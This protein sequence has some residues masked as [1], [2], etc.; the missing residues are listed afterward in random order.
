MD[1]NQPFI[2]LFVVLFFSTAFIFSFSH[3]GAQAVEKITNASGKFSD[4]TQIGFLDVSGKTESEAI[5]LME[6]TYV[7]WL[8]NTS[9]E[10]QCEEIT[11]PFDV[12]QFKLNSKQT[13]DSIKDGQKNLAFITINKSQVEEQVQ[14]LFPQL[15]SSNFD[16]DKLT[17]SL[18][19][20]ASLYEKG[21]QTFNLHH[22][23]LLSSKKDTVLN[24]AVV[25]MKDVPY[26]LQSV[27]E[28][29]PT[30]EIPEESTFSLLNFATE[31]KMDKSFALNEIATGIYQA[32]LPSNFS[33]I[34]RNIGSALPEY[35]SLGFEAKINLDKK[36]DLVFA[37]PNKAK[38]I[39]KVQLENNRL[40]VS[41]KGEKLLYDY[42][43]ST[44][45]EQK[46]K[47]KTIVQYS[48][49]LLSG[50]T[51]IKT[52]GEE[53]QM[54]KIYRDVYQV[55][56]LI[57]SELISE[58]YYPPVYQV[59]VHSLSGATQTNG[60]QSGS[61]ATTQI[62]TIPTPSANTTEPTITTSQQSIDESDLWGKPN[63]QPK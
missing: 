14:I 2:K 39:L 40:T 29:N 25:E 41:L 34:E 47:P 18:N 21:S 27:I 60:T 10:L 33:I 52:K 30:I 32:I 19:G 59:E 17:S 20:A 9:M 26:D 31:H 48:P 51:M 1:K 13:V 5:S 28:K 56:Q 62:V 36:A 53:G 16:L 38:Y 45:D 3:F 63:E 23:Y 22:D 44:K 37:N 7:D 43:I 24:V 55:D 46:L 11:V 57:R 58:D 8:K 15:K 42:E 12:N 50:K 49:L 61:A 35:A 54:A 4:G 6:E